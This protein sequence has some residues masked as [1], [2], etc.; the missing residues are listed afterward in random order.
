[1]ANAFQLKII[2]RGLNLEDAALSALA[3]SLAAA[4]RAEVTDGSLVCTVGCGA[5]VGR[6]VVDF[7]PIPPGPKEILSV[8]TVVVT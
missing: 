1:M 6:I 7:N 8:A 4:P 2:S 3:D 5:A